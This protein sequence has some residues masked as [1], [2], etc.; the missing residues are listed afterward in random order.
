VCGVGCWGGKEGW[1]NLLRFGGDGSR[2]L[3]DR[4]VE[5]LYFWWWSPLFVLFSR[6]DV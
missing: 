6:G 4:K 2:G 1:A 5:G 3:L